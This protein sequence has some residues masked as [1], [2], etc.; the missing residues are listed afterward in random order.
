M[1]P[2]EKGANI[3][4]H[5]GEIK[6]EAGDEFSGIFVRSASLKVYGGKLT[7]EA[8]G[9][10]IFS[11]GIE[12]YGGEVDAT[13]TTSSGIY[14][15]PSPLIVYGGKVKGTGASE[16]RGFIG[17]VQSGTEDIKFYF[18]DDNSN[19]GDGNSYASPTE[20]IGKRYAKAE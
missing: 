1:D 3:E 19:W 4:I 14:C 8:G 15:S 13:S 12:V 20:A 2:Q 18:S 10:S 6:A 5:G 17:N 11:N 7:V 9:T 16:N